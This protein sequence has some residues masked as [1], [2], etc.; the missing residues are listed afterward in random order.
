MSIDFENELNEA[1]REAVQTTE[2]PVLVIAGPGL[3][4]PAPSSIGWPTL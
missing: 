4:K 3:E 2:G 1:Q